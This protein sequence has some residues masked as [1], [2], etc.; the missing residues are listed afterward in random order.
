MKNNYFFSFLL[1]TII[2]CKQKAPSIKTPPTESHKTMI[3]TTEKLQRVEMTIDGM[4]CAISC[5][6]TIEKKLNA[7][8][9]VS[10]A[11]VDFDT[12]KAL[13]AFDTLQLNSIQLEEIIKGVGDA[14]SVSEIITLD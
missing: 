5:A 11:K 8:E 6:A 12:K 14:Y 7:A 3:V 4:M 1:I 10:I 13:I 2:A 9:G